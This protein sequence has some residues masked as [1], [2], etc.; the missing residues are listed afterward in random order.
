MHLLSHYYDE[1]NVKRL[2]YLV[3]LAHGTARW[4]VLALHLLS[5]HPVA[6]VV[7]GGQWS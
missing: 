1:Y 6:R 2:R 4:G 5:R 3:V 7:R